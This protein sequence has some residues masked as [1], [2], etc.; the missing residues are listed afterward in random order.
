MFLHLSLEMF[1]CSCKGS[2]IIVIV[3]RTEMCGNCT[4]EIFTF[5]FSTDRIWDTLFCIFTA[6]YLAIYCAVIA[7]YCE[8]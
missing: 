6:C 1:F 5:V 3:C 4:G 8:D 2:I 7:S